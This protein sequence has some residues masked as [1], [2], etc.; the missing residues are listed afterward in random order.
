[1]T[2]V[3]FK[4][5]TKTYIDP[6]DMDRNEFMKNMDEKRYQEA[7]INIEKIFYPLVI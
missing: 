1:M 3:D 2:M 6:N 5:S 4:D 7:C